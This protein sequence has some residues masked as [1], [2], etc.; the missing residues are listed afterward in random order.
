MATTTTTP[1]QTEELLKA[2]KARL[3]FVPNLLQEIKASPTALEIYLKGMN[4]LERSALSPREQQAVALAISSVNNCEYCQAAHAWVGR[5][6]GI[7]Q[8]EVQAIRAGRI[9]ES[10]ELAPVVRAARLVMDKKGWLDAAERQELGRQGVT[11][12]RLFDIIALIGL[13]TISNYVNH[14]AHTPVDE[15]FYP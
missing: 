6:V 9:P 1:A 7:A 2:E 8:A 10:P 15:Q 13:K 4:A 12:A 3:G 5:K 11:R 14:I